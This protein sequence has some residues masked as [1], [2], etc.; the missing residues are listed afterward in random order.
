M[1]P[2]CQNKHAIT[3]KC[4]NSQ[5]NNFSFIAEN[6]NFRLNLNNFCAQL[7]SDAENHVLREGQENGDPMDMR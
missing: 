2:N 4:N 5:E 6:S 3:P 1:T 7:Q